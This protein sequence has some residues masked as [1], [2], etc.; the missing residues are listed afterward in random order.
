M[1]WRWKQ[2][3]KAAAS[4]VW[5]LGAP[6][7]SILP[8]VMDVSVSMTTVE[9]LC[10]VRCTTTNKK[11]PLRA[12]VTDLVVITCIFFF[13]AAA[14][15][16]SMHD[17]FFFFPS[18]KTS[19][20]FL[21]FLVEKERNLSMRTLWM[22][23]KNNNRSA[24]CERLWK[25]K[26][27]GGRNNLQNSM[28]SVN[29]WMVPPSLSNH[30]HHFLLWRC[31]PF[32]H[33]LISAIAFVTMETGLAASLSGLVVFFTIARLTAPVAAAGQRAHR[34]QNQ[35][36]ARHKTHLCLLLHQRTTA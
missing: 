31:F 8:T 11:T 21:F 29:I 34:V 22:K 17:C 13:P 14:E 36:L 26:Q 24:S 2:G 3:C 35:P 10:N 18:I 33:P 15:T 6:R 16:F 1:W 12:D 7:G 19:Q 23:P 27:R 32:Q 5:S 30:H 25:S 20:K 28:S 4:R 9:G